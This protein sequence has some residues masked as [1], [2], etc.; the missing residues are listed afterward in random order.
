MDVLSRSG[1]TSSR[2]THKSCK[3]CGRRWG[4]IGIVAINFEQG[5]LGDSLPYCRVCQTMYQVVQRSFPKHPGLARYIRDVFGQS[6][7]RTAIA[8]GIKP[9]LLGK[10]ITAQ[11]LHVVRTGTVL[12]ITEGESL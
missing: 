10:L 8:E 7:L 11:L 5:P 3:L 9:E 4:G 2:K 1:T 12:H 6:F